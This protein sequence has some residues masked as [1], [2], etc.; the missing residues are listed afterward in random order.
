MNTFLSVVLGTI[1]IAAARGH[2]KPTMIA[3]IVAY[4]LG[5]VALLYTLSLA[6]Q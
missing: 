3:Q 4:N 5:G 1:A 2:A 6:A